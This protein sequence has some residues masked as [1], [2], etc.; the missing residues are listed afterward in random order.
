MD[1]FKKSHNT[2]G[3]VNELTNLAHI[4]NYHFCRLFKQST[5]KT[6]IEYI[7]ELRLR[8]AILLL[9]DSTLSITEIALLCSFNDANYFSRVFKNNIKM[10]PYQVRKN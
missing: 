9:K 7:N 2:Q 3:T 6:V 8:K 4:S 5:G 10:S 1:I